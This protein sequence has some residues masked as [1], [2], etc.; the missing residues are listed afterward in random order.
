MKGISETV[1]GVV[2][3]EEMLNN[4]GKRLNITPGVVPD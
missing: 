4:A 1:S 3:K 2:S